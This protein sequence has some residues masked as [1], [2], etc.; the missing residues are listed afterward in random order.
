MTAVW[1]NG[2]LEKVGDAR[3]SAFDA[4]FQHAVGL[5]E[6]MTGRGSRVVHLHQH[7]DRL[8]VSLRET[9]LSDRLKS[10]P[11]SDAIHATVA[12]AALETS[13]VRLTISGGDLNLLHGGAEGHEPTI[14]IVAHGNSL[15][16]LVKHLDGISDEDIAALNIPTGIPLVY[17]LDKDLKPIIPGGEY[18]DPDA[19]IAAAAAVAAQGKKK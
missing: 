9:R 8:E 14:L 4:G 16:A 1:L 17:T 5:F 15:R 10:G 19:A 7:L 6:T 2:T 11:L 12:A 3:I 18:L 13:R